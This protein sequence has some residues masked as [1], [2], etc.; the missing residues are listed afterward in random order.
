MNKKQIFEE[1][2]AYED[3]EKYS[4]TEIF[5]TCSQSFTNYKTLKKLKEY[6]LPQEN[7]DKS[8]I[9]PEMSIIWYA[10]NYRLSI[11]RY[12]SNNY[13]EICTFNSKIL[14]V[15]IFIPK[16]GIFNSKISY[17]FIVFTENQIII[18]GVDK[19]SQ[20]LI[21]TNFVASTVS[22]CLCYCLKNGN[23]F[24]GCED[25]NVYE[26]IYKSLD[27][28]SF[29]LMYLYSPDTNLLTNL[30]PTILR[31]KKSKIIKMSSN[32]KFLIVLSKKITVYNIE[33]GIFKIR[34]ISLYKEYI[35][36]QLLEE[37]ND[38]LFFYCVQPDG[39]RDFYDTKYLYTKKC[40]IDT[41]EKED[42]KI[43]TFLNKFIVLEKN[44]YQGSLIHFITV[45]EFQKTN[46]DRNK[47][48]ENQ[49]TIN[50]QE[51]ITNFFVNGKFLFLIS[52]SKISFYEILD[53]KQFVIVSRIEEVYNMFKNLGL[54][55]GLALYFDIFSM[56][57][58][59]SKLEYLCIKIDENHIKGLF[60][61]IYRQMKKFLNIKIF[62]ILED[63]N[64]KN[65][66]EKTVQKFKNLISKLKQN[67]FKIARDFMDYFIQS[68]NYV[69]VIHEYNIN[70]EDMTFY[71]LLLNDEAEFKKR[72]LDSL[73][74]IFKTNQS[75][76]TL[77][78]SLSNKS[79]DYL[80]LDEIYYHKGFDL[81][82]KYPSKDKLWESLTNF[83]NI[84]FNSEI[85]KKF[86]ELKFFTGSII[87]IRKH[88]DQEL[89]MKYD[90][91]E[92]VNLLCPS[93]KC[94]GSITNCLEDKRE[95][96]LYS[97][98]DALVENLLVKEIKEDCACCE[99]KTNMKLPD[100]IKLESKFLSKYL[101]EKSLT[102]SNPL[103]YELYWKYCAY[104]D[105]RVEAVKS[106]INLID[107]KNINL[108]KRIDL[109]KK[110]K[111]VS[112][113]SPYHD[114]IKKRTMLSN[115]QLELL[116]RGENSK[117]I[118][119]Q[120]LSSDKLFNDF[121]YKYPDLALKIIDQS[122]FKDKNIIRKYL[123]E[124]LNEDFKS[125]VNFLISN[126]F[127]GTVLD[128]EMIGEILLE[129]MKQ[130]DELCRNLY[131]IG[132]SYQEIENF[133]E[134]KIKREDDL[135]FKN[136]LMEDFRVFG[137]DKV[138]NKKPEELKC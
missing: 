19:I 102:N 9:I 115:I 34:E 71:R 100:I 83:K 25:G 93:I 11:F 59:V 63:D 50:L 119:F 126:K 20:A 95:D 60:S 24:I 106:L 7:Y 117:N 4:L 51:E 107:K 136:F 129:K 103:I 113:H 28:W 66:M 127:E 36:C 72:S 96:F 69:T 104:R 137:D 131:E 91:E 45:N 55:E 33:S 47:A 73:M 82:K 32:E 116:E 74:E 128:C 38:N 42:L 67:E 61:F 120:L 53:L 114:E 44:R 12:E 112:L 133:I 40:F 26:V 23:I 49:E 70:L 98:F 108:E 52:K 92:V 64:L 76:D 130:G 138:S 99:I 81:L 29:K 134:K 109:L 41:T 5:S 22:K 56:N 75:L 15:D 94:N 79:K 97:F 21:N 57:C 90:H 88:Y 77:I 30:I 105:D 6:S 17:C 39:S 58:D 1:T 132:F 54:R 27:S 62:K 68:V 43:K 84:N 2:K 124:C 85:I 80:P 3:R 10:H 111:T 18:Y 122:I 37:K 46:I 135:E 118:K 123:N 110:A 86:N 78:S 31:R 65:E 13:E 48:S 89:K 35:D 16:K 121:A 101:Q 125:S 87:L 14:F 8:G